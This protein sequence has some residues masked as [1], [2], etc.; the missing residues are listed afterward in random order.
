MRKRRKEKSNFYIL[1]AIF[2]LVILFSGYSY[3]YKL[4]EKRKVNQEVATICIDYEIKDQSE[5]YDQLFIKLMSKFNIFF[6]ET[7]KK[8]KEDDKLYK[9]EDTSINT[10]FDLL[11][12][13]KNSLNILEIIKEKDYDTKELYETKVYLANNMKED[14]F[15][16]DNNMNEIV[17]REGS[18]RDININYEEINDKT[19]IVIYHTHATESYIPESVNYYHSQNE[20]YNVLGLGKKLCE[21]LS[22]FGLNVKHIG[23][24]NDLP[25]Y[26]QSYLKSCKVVE[27]EIKDDKKNILIDVHRDAGDK[28]TSYEKFLKGVTKTAINDKTVATFSLVIGG[29]NENIDKLKEIAKIVKNNS[30]KLYPGLC[31]D[32]II[33]PNSY[34]N[35]DLSDYS[36][37]IEIGSNYNTIEEAEYTCDLISEILCETIIEINN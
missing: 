17:S 28:N 16:I 21:N 23:A 31:R 27:A 11:D 22:N 12:N 15:I 36:L 33:R 14:F 2:C 29:S 4:A 10:I 13:N 6:K 18:I 9:D 25:T 26:S 1:I 8:L 20:K 34:F 35:Q 19:N 30:D 5:K 37:L 7:Y 24:Y 3:V 32:I